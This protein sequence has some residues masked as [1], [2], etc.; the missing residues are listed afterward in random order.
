MRIALVHDWLLGISGTERVIKALHEIFPEAPIYTLLE[1][2]AFTTNFLPKATIIPSFLQKYYDRSVSHRLLGLAMPLA[3]EAFDL[4][5]YDLVISSAPTYTKG[6]ILRPSTLHINY[7]YSPTRQ[8]WDWH[9]EYKTESHTIPPIITGILQHM[10]RIWD[11]QAAQRVDEYIAISQSVKERIAKYYRREATIIYPPVDIE[12]YGQP[13][14]PIERGYFLIV[15]RLFKHKN[16][17]IAI[18]AFNKMGWPLVVIGE[19]PEY[20]RLRRLAGSTI[21]LLGYQTD[22]VVKSYMAHCKAYIM[23]LEEDFGIAPIEAMSYGK[24]VLAL[25]RGGAFEYLQEGTNGEFFDDPIEEVLAYGLK[26]INDKIASYQ[27][28]VIKQSVAHF[29]K[30]RFKKEILDFIENKTAARQRAAGNRTWI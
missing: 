25:R 2:R 6:L 28:E 26:R 22:D 18:Q 11:T 27:P 13:S 30:D 29:A 23:P 20:Q 8:L 17:A 15:S 19:G 3:T 4:S 5:D 7:C 12:I 1:N 14:P 21:K 10:G 9:T 16:I 24:P